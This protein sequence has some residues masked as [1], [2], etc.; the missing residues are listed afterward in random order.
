V[1][2]AIAALLDAVDAGISHQEQCWG[3]YGGECNCGVGRLIQLAAAVREE[4]GRELSDAELASVYQ[5]EIDD[6]TME[7]VDDEIECHRRGL[8]AVERRVR[9]GQ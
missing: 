1:S 2:T 9:E 3:C 8:R 4:M 7:F 5:R 6:A